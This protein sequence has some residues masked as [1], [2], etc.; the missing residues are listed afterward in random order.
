[1]KIGQLK[2]K[3]E[4]WLVEAKKMKIGQSRLK[5][6][7]KWL[8]EAKNKNWLVEAKNKNWLVAASS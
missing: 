5:M 6:K 4:N 7:M 1:M 2:A 8:V 3:N